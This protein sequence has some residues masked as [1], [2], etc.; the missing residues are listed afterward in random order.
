M[1]FNAYLDAVRAQRVQGEEINLRD[2]ALLHLQDRISELEERLE[3][4]R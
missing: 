4:M 2:D 1:S 3:R